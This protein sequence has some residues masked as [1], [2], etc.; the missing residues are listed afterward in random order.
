MAVTINDVARRARVSKS[1]VSLVLNNRPN[2]S[3]DTR[4]AV[5]QAI[6]ELGYKPLKAAQAI[7]TKKTRNIGFMEIITTHESP[8]KLATK[9]GF[10]TMIPT[11]A[12]DVARG[13]EDEAQRRGYGLLFATYY[14][15]LK[16]SV[17]S[18]PPMVQ[19][20]WVDGIMLVGGSFTEGYVRI[21]KRWKIPVV[22][23][24]S[25]L[26]S[27]IADC[28]YAD[29]AWGAFQ[30]ADYLIGLGHRRIGFINGPP[31][32]QTTFDKMQGYLSALQKHGLEYDEG[33]VESGD[34]SAQ[35]GY[36]AVNALLDRETGITAFFVGFDG[37]SV[38]ALRALRERGLSVPGDVSVVSFE[39]SWL[40]THAYPPLT[41]VKVFKY[42]LGIQA[43]RMLFDLINADREKKPH[44]VVIPT[45]L[46]VRQSCAPPR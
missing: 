29:N 44:K 27:N 17:A 24:G 1:T 11:F 32:T 36:E 14:G 8:E 28:V 39:D 10:E 15:E 23:V 43:T 25:Y 20:Y 21:L 3:E 26:S 34:F 2:V 7:T 31:T 22:L 37:M 40:A 45:E 33:L 18:V 6:E 19:N 35:S 13:I 38:G 41:T 5:L 30:A 16:T 9:Y 42:E 12:H 46:I 4:A